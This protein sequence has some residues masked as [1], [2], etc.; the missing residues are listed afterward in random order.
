MKDYLSTGGMMQESGTILGH[1]P[2]ILVA[3][4]CF[5]EALTIAQVI[6]Q[7]RAALP[8]AHIVVFDNNS[9]DGSAEIAR[10][11]GARV[12]TVPMQGKGNVVRR[13]FADFDADAYVMADADATYDAS[14]ARE[15]L[16][17]VLRGEAD[18]VVGVRKGAAAAFPAGHLFGNKLF[19]FL[20]GG[21]FGRGL[22]DIFSGYRVFSRRFAKSFPA[23]SEGFEI[24]TEMSIYV[25]EQRMPVLEIDTEYGVR[26][27]GSFSKLRTWRDG[28]RISLTILRLFKESRPLRFFTLLAGALVV[29]SLVLGLPV[30]LEWRTTGLVE[31]LPTAILSACVGVLAVII[32]VAGMMLDS[33]A[34]S[35]RETR[36]FRYM[37]VPLRRG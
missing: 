18:M 7:F 2:T 15:L 3:L 31:R 17:P 16:M 35:Y 28:L 11:A 4:P 26:P 33:I 25:L 24:E 34:R 1:A 19:N 27:E 10:A 14:R 21:L 36:H 20:V 9:R 22:R 29:L 6:A 5:N 13:L 12:V 37:H 30:V 8:E 32:F 23:H